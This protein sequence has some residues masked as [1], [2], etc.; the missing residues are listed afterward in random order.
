MRPINLWRRC[1][2]R[3]QRNYK[4]KFRQV[5]S[6]ISVK[7]VSN[8][9]GQNETPVEVILQSSTVTGTNCCKDNGEGLPGVNIVE[10]GTTNGTITDVNG[11]YR[12]NV[13]GGSDPCGELRWLCITGSAG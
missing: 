4:L 10:K 11:S 5:N 7:P 9:D 8:A 1:W 3:S 6:N 2:S 13:T 12:I